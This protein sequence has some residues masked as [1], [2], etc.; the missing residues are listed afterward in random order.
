MYITDFRLVISNLQV[1]SIYTILQTIFFRNFI[2][3]VLFFNTS[4]FAKCYIFF[5]MENNM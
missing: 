2:F 5:P 4:D 3:G 1:T